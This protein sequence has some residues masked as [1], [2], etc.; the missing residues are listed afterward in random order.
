MLFLRGG[1]G[2][3]G[4][5]SLYLVETND[6]NRLRF[7]NTRHGYVQSIIDFYTHDLQG[8]YRFLRDNGAD[9]NEV[10]FE[11][12]PKRFGFGFRDPDGNSLGV[13]NAVLEGQAAGYA[14][15]GSPVNETDGHPYISRI[16]SIEIPVSNLRKAVDW[17][18]RVL[19]LK[20]FG[21]NR[22]EQGT[23]MMYLSGGDRIGVPGV[24]LVEND[25]P[26]RIS[27]VNTNTGITH[28]VFDFYVRNV[29]SFLE[30]LKASGIAINGASGFF[31][32]DGNSLA[33]CDAL[34]PEQI[35]P[36]L[37]I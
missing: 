21:G 13:C 16:A 3:V 17:Y 10:D 26:E 6:T 22:D 14:S 35:E 25:G 30:T 8:Y 12:E 1:K 4:I 33:V 5:P 37:A 31:D 36:A 11:R 18:S 32:P 7:R 29:G 19:G 15:G 27:F 20:P 23:L 2:G 9:V 34:F 28:S 24:Y